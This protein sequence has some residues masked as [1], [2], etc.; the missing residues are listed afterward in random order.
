MWGVTAKTSRGSRL[1]LG[2]QVLISV[3]SLAVGVGDVAATST[4]AASTNG[5]ATP[6]PSRARPALERRGLA[7][8]ITACTPTYWVSTPVHCAPEATEPSDDELVAVPGCN[9]SKCA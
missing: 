2:S 3:A 7:A 1:S 4:P 5:T 6:T 8:D 9:Y